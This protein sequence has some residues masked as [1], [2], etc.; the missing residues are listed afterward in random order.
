MC[1]GAN[2]ANRL[3]GNAIPE[4]FVFGEIAG[5]SAANT[6]SETPHFSLQVG[7]NALSNLLI[8]LSRGSKQKSPVKTVTSRKLLLKLQK[9]MWENVGVLRNKKGLKMAIDEIRRMKNDIFPNLKPVSG[10]V[11]NTSLMD[12]LD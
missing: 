6:D 9:I 5:A 7:Q 12:W 3:S 11:F 10:T 8:E 4:A 1:G 2:G